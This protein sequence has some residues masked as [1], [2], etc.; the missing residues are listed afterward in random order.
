M[1]PERFKGCHFPKGI[2][3]QAVYWYLRYALRVLSQNCIKYPFSEIT[4]VEIIDD[5]LLNRQ[6]M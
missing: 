6:E 4:P 1:N 3:L 2:V 5:F